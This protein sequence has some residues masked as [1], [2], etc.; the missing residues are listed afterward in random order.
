MIKKQLIDI[1]YQVAKNK[2]E[3]NVFS[4]TDLWKATVKEEGLDKQTQKERIG[5]LHV[6]MLQDVRFIYCGSQKWR[7]REF[8]T[9]EEF[10]NLQHS[11]YDFNSEVYEEGFETMNESDQGFDIEEQYTTAQE[12]NADNA[13]DVD[14]DAE[15]VY[16]DINS[17][18]SKLKETDEDLDEE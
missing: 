11:L 14:E 10:N 8:A 17:G 5:A 16:E 1:A 9:I 12:Y 4:F 13:D 6:D 3:K 7:L 2:Y 15:E 18:I